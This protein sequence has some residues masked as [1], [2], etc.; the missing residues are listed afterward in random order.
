MR[1]FYDVDELL[2]DSYM[3]CAVYC[4]ERGNNFLS[5]WVCSEN[6]FCSLWNPVPFIIF[7]GKAIAFVFLVCF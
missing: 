7:T 6:Y 1:D 2:C 4:I 5:T 3:K